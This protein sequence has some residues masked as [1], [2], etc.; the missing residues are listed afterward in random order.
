MQHDLSLT[1]EF[2][3]AQL[4]L[5]NCT[6][7]F[8]FEY[9]CGFS[10]WLLCQ[11]EESLKS[12]PV[13]DTVAQFASVGLACS[14][15]ARIVH[16][17]PLLTPEG[18]EFDGCASDQEASRTV[19]FALQRATKETTNPE[20]SWESPRRWAA[21]Q[22]EDALQAHAAFKSEYV[23]MLMGATLEE[24][25][26]L[27]SFSDEEHA[28]DLALASTTA[29]ELCDQSLSG[30]AAIARFDGSSE[31]EQKALWTFVARPPRSAT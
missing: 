4:R 1:S 23:V 30:L 5:S 15:V 29:L 16:D 6:D 2:T 25:P 22:S 17:A 13:G 18:W 28:T 24:L 9:L 19:A 3:N 12:H 10:H 8:R 20:H 21:G 11:F 26:Q 14:L 27:L 7:T 31:S